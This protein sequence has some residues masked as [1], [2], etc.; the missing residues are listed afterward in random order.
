MFITEQNDD[1]GTTILSI[2]GNNN[3]PVVTKKKKKE[4]KKKRKKTSSYNC[5]ERQS[6]LYLV[7]HSMEEFFLLP[8]IPKP[9][10]DQNL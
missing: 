6:I 5:T 10:S 8:T 4:K 2:F 9:P 7:L 3:K 1:K